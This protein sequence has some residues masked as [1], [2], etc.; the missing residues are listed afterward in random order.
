MNVR[1]NAFGVNVLRTKRKSPRT[2]LMIDGHKTQILVDT[3]S[4]IN[5][6]NDS[7]VSKMKVKP[8]L[9]KTD[10]KAY[11]YGQK[12]HLPMKG[13]FTAT[14]ETDKKVTTG[15]FYVIS[16]RYDSVAEL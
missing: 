2:T 4:T 15:T 14:V 12:E 11:A 3:G 13:K 6:L 7:V 5:I 1:I 9:I 16:G 8:K 10:T